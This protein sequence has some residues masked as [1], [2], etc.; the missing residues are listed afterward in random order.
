MS[1]LR[2]A[3]EVTVLLINYTIVDLALAALA[4]QLRT[5][6]VYILVFACGCWAVGKLAE[7]LERLLHRRWLAFALTLVSFAAFVGLA[8]WLY[9]AVFS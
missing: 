1:R 7:D 8:W 9:P 2:L 6:W 4:M 5:H 3:F